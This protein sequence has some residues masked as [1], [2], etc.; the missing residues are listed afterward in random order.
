MTGTGPG[1]TLTLGLGAASVVA[2]EFVVIGLVPAMR[3]DLGLSPSEAGWL[4]TSFALAS[5]LAGPALVAATARFRPAPVMAAALAPFAGGVL[6]LFLPSFALAVLL[7]L[8][9]GATLPLFMSV[10]TARLAATQGIGRGVATLYI[11]VTIGGT[12]A[13]PLGA[14]AADRFGWAAVMAAPGLLAIAAAAACL[15]FGGTTASDRPG[16]AWRRLR[17]PA[18]RMHLLLSALLFATMFCGFSYSALLLAGQGL[19]AAGITLALL[20]FGLAGLVGNWLAGSAARQSLGFGHLVA[21]VAAAAAAWLALAPG[22]GSWRIAML[23]PLWGI[24][25]AAGFVFCQ[26]RVMA[27]LPDAPA[28]AGALNISAANIGIAAGSFIG[29]LAL[30][31]AGPVALAAA[32]IALALSSSAAT[33]RIQRGAAR[34]RCSTARTSPDLP[35]SR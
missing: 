23:M 27:A 30:T 25:H 26:V 6:L 29:G 34:E 7:R 31:H 18:L 33:L 17:E 5:A 14:F 21:A 24:A 35:R 15:R 19:D 1:A 12:L 13:P 11:G 20:G 10:A 32:C 8:A 2:A 9:Q 28:F 16:A 3:A 4:V 22:A